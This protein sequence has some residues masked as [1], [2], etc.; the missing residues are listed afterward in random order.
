[1]NIEK[2]FD[3]SPSGTIILGPDVTCDGFRSEYS[4]RIQTHV[5]DDHM[6]EFETSKGYQDILMT[7]PTKELLIAEK[8]ADLPIRDNIISVRVGEQIRLGGSVVTLVKNSHMLGSVQVCVELENGFRLGYSGDFQWPCEHRMEVDYLI[9]DSTNGDRTCVREYSQDDAQ[10]K[11][12]EL[13]ARKI[14]DG[15]IH[16]QGYRGTLQ[17]GLQ[18]LSD[19]VDVPFL[20]SNNLCKQVEVY[21][22]YGYAVKPL[23]DVRSPEGKAA[24]QSARFI[25]FYGK[26]DKAPVDLSGETS[27]W[28]SAYLS[29]AD[30]PIVELAPESYTIA[31]SDHAD[32]PGILDYVKSTGARRVLCD[33]TRTGKGIELAQALRDR[34]GIDA[35]PSKQDASLE[36]GM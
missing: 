29:G 5:H 1:M 18:C 11:L 36:W 12:I 24:V 16:I 19:V 7:E 26:G 23:I 31:L 25:K 35:A 10:A 28:L 4:T 6:R 8:N 22:K 15:P 34:L 3:V 13:V 20:G 33:N 21:R 14:L 17:R 32:F 30:R 9:L 2:H 27:I